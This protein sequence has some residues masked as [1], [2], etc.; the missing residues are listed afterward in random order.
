MSRSAR[1]DRPGGVTLPPKAARTWA[2]SRRSGHVSP[3]AAGPRGSGRAGLSACG[4]PVAAASSSA[5]PPP[6][7]GRRGPRSLAAPQRARA[8]RPARLAGHGAA[9]RLA[10]LRLAALQIPVARLVTPAAVEN[11]MLVHAAF[12][13]SPTWCSTSRPSRTRRACRPVGGRLAA[14]QPCHPRLVDA[15]P[16]ARATIPRCACSWPEACRRSCCTCGASAASP[17]RADRD[18]ETLDTTWTGGRRAKGAMDE[19]RL[20]QADGVSADDVIMDPDTARRAASRAWPCSRWATGAR[21]VGGEGHGLD[22][23]VVE[24]RCTGTR[25]R[26]RLHRGEGGDRGDQGTRAP[27]R[28][29]DVW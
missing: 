6:P 1:C 27:V 17:Q 25:A 15:L 11:A 13:G 20:R 14:R 3:W 21:R 23:S 16:T 10:L 26:A 2:R 4:S 5:R 9:L 7:G 12:G 19:A 28:P 24:A 22:P 29:G 18:G 8:V